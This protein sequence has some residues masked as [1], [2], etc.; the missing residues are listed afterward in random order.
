VNGKARRLGSVCTVLALGLT[1]LGRCAG[2]DQVG[3]PRPLDRVRQALAE[4]WEKI[5]LIPESFRR[6][7]D[8]DRDGVE[9]ASY[10]A[11]KGDT[12]RPIQIKTSTAAGPTTRSVFWWSIPQKA[13]TAARR[14]AAAEHKTVTRVLRVEE[15]DGTAHF[16]VYAA[17][18]VGLKR[19]PETVLLS[20]EDPR[21]V[22]KISDDTPPPAG[23]R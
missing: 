17:G 10:S 16:E 14:Y 3:T 8:R 22:G 13:R 7:R 19:L 15:P 12:D 20:V 2:D 23:K 11:P 1:G 21:K 5:R 9:R 18:R 6:D 4:R